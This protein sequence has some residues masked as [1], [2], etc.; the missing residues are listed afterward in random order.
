[1]RHVTAQI[2]TLI[3]ATAVGLAAPAGGDPDKDPQMMKLLQDARHLL[4]SKNP[5]SRDR[6]VRRGD[7]CLQSTLRQ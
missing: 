2:L 5:R 1:M 4:D 3:V 6:K 7:Q